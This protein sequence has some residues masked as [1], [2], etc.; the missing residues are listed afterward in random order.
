[1][2]ILLI[3][4]IL[5]IDSHIAFGE[6]PLTNITPGAEEQLVTPKGGRLAQAGYLI[7]KTP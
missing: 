5:L 4:S 6:N 2:Y 3:T 1:V 7:A